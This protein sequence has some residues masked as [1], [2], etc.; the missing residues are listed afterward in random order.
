MCPVSFCLIRFG[1]KVASETPQ[2]C[3]LVKMECMR[4]FSLLTRDSLVNVPCLF[5]PFKCAAV[6]V[7]PSP[8]F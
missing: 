8:Y 7:V 5:L 3:L 6:L 2:E 1:C 4:I